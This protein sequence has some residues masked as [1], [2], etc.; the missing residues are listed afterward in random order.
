M[1]FIMMFSLFLSYGCAVS[2]IMQSVS[3]LLA[4]AALVLP[5]VAVDPTVDLG[6]S[7]YKG[8]DLGNGVS[9]WLGVRYGAAPVKD[10]RWSM[11]K[12]PSR[13]RAVQDAT[14][15]SFNKAR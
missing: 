2:F 13:V 9:E 8:K 6:Y 14:K 10:L 7:K 3:R 11:P 15:V 4:F 1:N 12:D 5:S